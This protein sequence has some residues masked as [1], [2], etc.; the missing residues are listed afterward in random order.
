MFTISI[1]HSKYAFSRNSKTLKIELAMVFR[2]F[3]A[4]HLDHQN[5]LLRHAT[6]AVVASLGSGSTENISVTM[7]ASIVW[8]SCVARLPRG[9][10]YNIKQRM[11]EIKLK[12][13]N[14]DKILNLLNNGNTPTS[15]LFKVLV[16]G[17]FTT[18]SLSMLLKW[19]NVSS[20]NF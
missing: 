4:L 15:F 16:G 8:R 19:P 11:N 6:T 12:R 17:Y 9:Q 1:F 20:T 14:L 2:Q 7:L 18:K 5:F 13:C 3:S 10:E